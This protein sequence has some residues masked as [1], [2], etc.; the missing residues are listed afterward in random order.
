MSKIDQMVIGFL[1]VKIS[2]KY[3]IINLFNN[4][5]LIEI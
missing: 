2:S 5:Y 4:F 1:F 3:I